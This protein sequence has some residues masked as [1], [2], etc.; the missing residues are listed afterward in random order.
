MSGQPAFRLSPEN[1]KNNLTC[2]EASFIGR[3]QSMGGILKGK[4]DKVRENR[5]SKGY[6]GSIT[7]L[8]I[9]HPA[10]LAQCEA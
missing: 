7:G 6:V 5:Y 8:F 10:S 3:P 1:E 9:S 4:I 2:E